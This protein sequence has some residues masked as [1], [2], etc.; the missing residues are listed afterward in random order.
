M[1]QFTRRPGLEQAGKDKAPN[2]TCEETGKGQES[3]RTAARPVRGPGLTNCCEERIAKAPPTLG[4]R[5]CT[6]AR[7]LTLARKPTYTVRAEKKGGG[8]G[9]AP[10]KSPSDTRDGRED[11]RF[12]VH[13]HK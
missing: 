5:S 9:K 1:K 6:Y 10:S 4:H 12:D 3:L 8:V 2:K 13:R 7:R 11:G